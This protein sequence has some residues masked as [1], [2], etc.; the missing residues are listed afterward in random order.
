M[1]NIVTNWVNFLMKTNAQCPLENFRMLWLEI[2]S[3]LKKLHTLAF[4]WC[5]SYFYTGHLLVRKTGNIVTTWVNFL[6]ETNTQCPLEN[7][8]MLWLEIHS[9]LAKASCFILLLMQQLF[10]YWSSVGQ[11]N[12]KYGDH[13]SELPDENK[14]S[15]P[16]GKFQNALVRNSFMFNKSFMLYPSVDATAIFILVFCWSEKREIWWPPEWTSWWKQ[17][18]SAPWKILECFG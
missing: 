1:G 16:P 17:M 5:N 12:G 4:F 15:V 14:C 18:L 13:L 8:R 7:F 3:Y 6:I 11:K 9:Y 10:L 2:H